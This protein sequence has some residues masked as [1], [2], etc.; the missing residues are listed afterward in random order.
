MAT[1]Y[2]IRKEIAECLDVSKYTYDAKAGKYVDT[3]T[4]EAF[5][6]EA[7]EQAINE[8]Y[9]SL[10]MDRHEKLHNV[11]LLYLNK[12]ADAAQYKAEKD[13][14]AAKEKAAKKTMDWAKETLARE[15]N[16]EKMNETEF[17]VSYRSSDPLEI[18]EGA[19]I[20]DEFLIQQAPK[21]DRAGIRKALQEGAII[22]GCK[23]A[24]R[25]NIQIR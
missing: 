22:P 5:S 23:L 7:I 4:G 16:G 21:V 17:S 13:R 25:S 12:K 14:F 24:K 15:L 8:R 18:E 2:E 20:P 6:P 11:G 10:Q 19:S 1:L 9:E 3:E